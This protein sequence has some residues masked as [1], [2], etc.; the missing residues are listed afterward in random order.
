M[1]LAMTDDATATR[2]NPFLARWD[3]PFEAPPFDKVRPEHFRPAFESA[4]ATH[5]AEIA[6]IAGDPEAPSFHNTIDALEK[7]GSVLVRVGRVFWNL[8]GSHTNPDLQATERQIAPVLAKHYSDIALN[9][10]LFLRVDAL[11]GKVDDLGLTAEQKRVL[12]RIHRNFVRAGARLEGEARTRLAAILERLASLGTQFSQNVLADEAAWSL[13]LD[14]DDDRAGLPDWFLEAARRTGEERGEP[15]R[16]VVT[17]ARSSVEPFLQFSTNRALREKA[18]KAWSGRGETGGATDNKAIVAEM[19]KLRA[20]RARLLG[21]PNFAAYKLDDT[22]AKTPEAVNELL[23]AV[24]SRATRQAQQ[25]RADLQELVAEDGLNFD[26]APHDWRH[27]ASR[28]RKIRHDLDEAALKPYFQLDNVIEAAFHVA[29]RLFGLSFRERGDV[30]VYHPDVR[31]W[32]VTDEAG[33]HVAL[34]YGDYFARP[35]KRSGAWMSA[36]RGQQKLAGDIRPIIVNVLNVAKAGE[37]RP[38][39]LGFDDAR[40]LFHEFGH[41]LHGMLSDVTYPSLAGTSVSSDFVE[42]PSQLYEH[43]FTQPDVLRRFAI[44]AETGEPISEEL[45]ARIEA[46]RNFNQGFATVEYTA[47]AL[48][49]MAFHALED[50]DGIDPIAFEADVLARLGMPEGVAMRHRTPHFAHVFSGDGYSAGYYSY[51]WSEVLDADG[52]AAFEAAGDIFDRDTADR[53]KRFVYAAGGTRDPAEA[54]RA[55]RGRD[56]SVDAL[57]RKRGFAD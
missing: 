34:F 27:Y 9:G 10:P 42:F 15:G 12:E 40:T 23:Q 8:T 24:W 54:Y 14:T 44:H 30:P 52:F 22:M 2:D 19:L 49:D 56:P 11:A 1:E 21:Y 7:A 5:R 50:A 31:A 45:L 37:G 33:N 3:T 6:A 32:E 53:L 16:A 36:F 25:E 18:F 43:W 17:L 13:P 55:F 39:L 4:L 35:S 41:A 46:A 51:L 20:E 38:A 26:I 28:L 48:V 57:M 47:S 29:N